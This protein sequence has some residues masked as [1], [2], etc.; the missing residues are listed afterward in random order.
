MDYEFQESLYRETQQLG[1]VRTTQYPRTKDK[2]GGSAVV[3]KPVTVEVL[4]AKVKWES[5]WR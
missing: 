5:I 4:A 1:R 2:D 3:K